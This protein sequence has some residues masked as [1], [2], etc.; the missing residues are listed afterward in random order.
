MTNLLKE[1][2]SYRSVNM[3]DET[4]I[5]DDVKEK[6]CF[7]AQDLAR[8]A[9]EA[10]KGLQSAHYGEYVLPDGV[11]CA[12]GYVRA[13]IKR[14]TTDGDDDE[15]D[16]DGTADDEQCLPLCNERF[17]TPEVLFCPSDIGIAQAGVH[18]LVAQAVRLPYRARNQRHRSRRACD[19]EGEPHAVRRR[20]QSRLRRP[21]PLWASASCL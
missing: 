11:R 14:N 3:M 17:M 20:R 15:D 4:Y 5:I 21:H 8:E 1:L 12:R 6:M 2:V 19:T 10:R 9:R 16:G 13:K 18:E 7:V